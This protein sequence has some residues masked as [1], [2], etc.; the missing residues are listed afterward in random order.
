MQPTKHSTNNMTFGP[1][2][3]WNH[4]GLPCSSVQATI[5]KLDEVPC[6]KTYWKPDEVELAKLLAGELVALSIIGTGMPP[7]M[8]SVEAL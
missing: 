7:V 8:L 5:G 4:D 6:V 1:P 3:G 2:E